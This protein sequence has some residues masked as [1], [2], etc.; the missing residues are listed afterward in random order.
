MR[1]VVGLEVVGVENQAFR[2]DRMIVGTQAL[3][4]HRVLHRLPI[5][6]LHELGC[7]LVGLA[8][9]Q[10]IRVR[11]EEA[12]AAALLPFRLVLGVPLLGRGLQAFLVGGGYPA[13][14]NGVSYAA[15]RRSA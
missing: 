11:E 12:D 1:L 7:R 14:P 3:R 13:I 4:G 2:A 6:S 5:F 8:V 9:L 15:R 10:E